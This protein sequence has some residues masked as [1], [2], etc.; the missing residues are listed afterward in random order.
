LE[1]GDYLIH[2][3]AITSDDTKVVQCSEDNSLKV[4]NLNTQKCDLTFNLDIPVSSIAVSKKGNLVAF[5]D[6]SGNIYT[7]Y[8]FP[9]LRLIS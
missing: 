5:G 9:K 1:G 3:I 7:G 8:L 2:F 6:Y 4:W